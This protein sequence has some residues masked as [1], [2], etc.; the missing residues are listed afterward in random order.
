MTRRVIDPVPPINI[1]IIVQERW[2]FVFDPDECLLHTFDGLAG[3]FLRGVDLIADILFRCVDLIA[4]IL[5]RSVDLIANILFRSVD[6]VADILLCLDESFPQVLLRSD[7]LSLHLCCLI[8]GSA[9]HV[10]LTRQV[11]DLLNKR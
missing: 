9:V 7:S 4:K 5:F 8:F 1:L 6:L 3:S 2:C 11:L 10:L